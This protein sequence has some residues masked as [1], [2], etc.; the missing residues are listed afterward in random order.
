VA[1]TREEVL[2]RAD[3]FRD[4]Q[5]ILRAFDLAWAQSQIELDHLHLTTGEAHLYQRLA[6]HLFYHDP[7]L[8]APE[9]VLAANRQ[10]QPGLWRHGISGDRPIVLV[11]IGAADELPLARQLLDAHAY[12]RLKGLEADLVLL[13]DE[14]TSYIEELYQ[15]L[16]QLI[17]ASDDN[18]LADRP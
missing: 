6:S 13:N 4:P 14:P 17:R 8:R 9:A 5:A 3:Q 16:Q 11:R 7:S 18:T 10:G 2:Q 12:W 15:Q 1:G